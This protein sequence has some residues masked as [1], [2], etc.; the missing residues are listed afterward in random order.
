MRFLIKMFFYLGIVAAGAYF[1]VN[2]IPSLK[3]NILE[4][5]N[6]RI[7]EGQL[8]RTLQQT[9]EELDSTLSS[10]GTAT[11][12]VTTQKKQQLVAESQELLREIADIN[13]KRDSVAV[14][15]VTKA[16]DALIGTTASPAATPCAQ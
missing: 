4:T 6:P 10:E 7:E 11:T 15:I 14:G 16:V 5:V 12:T 13:D 1:A 3:A 8:V 2:N 9:L